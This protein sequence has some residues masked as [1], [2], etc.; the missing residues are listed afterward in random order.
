MG[1]LKRLKFWDAE[2]LIES[3]VEAVSNDFRHY[4]SQAPERDRHCWLAAA[5]SNRPGYQMGKDV[6][7]IIPFTRTTLFSVLEDDEATLSLA[8]YF[9]S[10]ETPHLVPKFERRWDD[11]MRPARDLINSGGLLQKWEETNPWTAQNIPGMSLAVSAITIKDGNPTP[12]SFC[13]QPGVE[14]IEL[15]D[16]EQANLSI[17]SKFEEHAA[18][19]ARRQGHCVLLRAAWFRGGDATGCVRKSR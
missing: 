9:L 3:T 4:K 2:A 7:A 6:G 16:D 18:A 19:L 10:Q 12:C 1:F 17:A 14:V 13:G 15:S 11:A 5:F 8:Y